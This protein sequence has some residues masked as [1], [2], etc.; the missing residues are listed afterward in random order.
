M[1]L[2]PFD[3]VNEDQ[4]NANAAKN[5]EKVQQYATSADP[6]VAKRIAEIYKKSPY[7]PANIVLAMAKQGVSDAAVDAI[8]PTA[9]N[10]RKLLMTRT[11]NRKRVG[12]HAM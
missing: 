6:A 5:Q 2:S 8:R 12:S 4:A 11:N 3:P 1:A 9:G 7:I 10:S